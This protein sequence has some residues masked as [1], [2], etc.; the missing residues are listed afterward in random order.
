MTQVKSF[1]AG[2]FSTLL[3]HQGVIALFGM[4][5]ELPFKSY[6]MSPT[7]PFGVPSL[8]SLAFFAGLWG[9]VIWA[10]IRNK[11]RKWQVIGAISLGAVLPTVVAFTIVLP[12]KGIE[13]KPNYIPFGLLLNGIWGLGVWALMYL[14]NLKD[15]K[16]THA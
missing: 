8:I 11:T 15:H 2:F 7:K 3:F 6:S 10:M 12:L 13:F 14:M 9:V 16:N 1:L 4:F 5:Q